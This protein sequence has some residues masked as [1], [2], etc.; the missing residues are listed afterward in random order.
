M[1][2]EFGERSYLEVDCDEESV[3][4]CVSFGAYKKRDGGM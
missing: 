4:C 3:P 2:K 1:T